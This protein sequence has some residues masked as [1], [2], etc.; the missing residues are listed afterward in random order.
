MFRIVSDG[1]CDFSGEEVQ[2]HDI[3]IVP[4]YISFDG[5]NYMRE[6]VDI[7]K[8]EFFD[9]LRTDKTLFPKTS[10][11]NPQDYIEALTP[12]LKAGNDVLVLTISSKLSGSYSS[13]VIAA[14][15]LR[16]DYPDRNIVLVD[17]LNGSVGQGLIL[18]E[19]I[20]M[21]G[22]GLSAK[23][24]GERAKKV[25]DT[26]RIYFTLDNLEYLRRGGRVGPTTAFVGGILGLRPI[27]QLVDGKVTQLDNVR[28]KKKVLK[29]IE[30]AMVEALKD[31][32]DS[33]SLAIGHILSDTDA[34]EL[35]DSIQSALDITIGNPIT[36][37]GVT[38]GAHIGPGA[39]AFA[40]CKKYDTI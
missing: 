13:A 22:A 18:R 38:I 10:Q 23:D 25:L 4:F 29:L 3:S 32:R 34:A 15:N 20:K 11:P 33:V 6:G 27:L 30:E 12:H 24:T 14:E 26:T 8:A 9:R 35:R 39:L 37:V 19:I 31:D 1:G 36:E 16:E 17:S 5:E 2:N 7:T 40:Y 28:G 21:R